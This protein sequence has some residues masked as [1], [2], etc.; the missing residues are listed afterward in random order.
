M[1]IS[2]ICFRYVFHQF[3]LHFQRCVCRFRNESQAVTDTVNVG[4]N[5]Q[6]WLSKPHSLYHISRLS[7]YSRKLSQVIRVVGNLTIETLHQYF[8]HLTQVVCLGVWIAHALYQ[9]EDILPI[10]LC[11]SLGRGVMAIEFRRNHI[12]SLVGTLCT[13]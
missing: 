9:L 4:I 10:S 3:Q 6:G 2:Y 7:A 1:C 11:H 5:G 12:D 8:C 13:E